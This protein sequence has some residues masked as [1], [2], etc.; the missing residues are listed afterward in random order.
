[1]SPVHHPADGGLHTRLHG[2]RQALQQRRDDHVR[3]VVQHVAHAAEV[4]RG[5]QVLQRRRVALLDVAPLVR[6][7]RRP[8]SRV[9]PSVAHPPS[10]VTPPSR[11]TRPP[12][13]PSPPN[14]PTPLN[15]PSPPIGLA[16]RRV[17]RISTQ[18]QN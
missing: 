7:L 8:E 18:S 4:T 5:G 6:P 11:V 16:A 13:V 9:A 2:G 15:L 10:S 12:C 1:M 14:L 17:R 3:H